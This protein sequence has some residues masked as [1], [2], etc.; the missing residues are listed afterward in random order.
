MAAFA[1]ES[2]MDELAQRLDGSDRAAAEER[3]QRGHQ[4]VL[5]AEW[6]DG[7]SETLK[8]AKAYAH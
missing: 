6:L 1:V 2:V 8:A 3:R 4:V 7:L 5:R